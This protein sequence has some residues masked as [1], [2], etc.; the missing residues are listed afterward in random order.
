MAVGVTESVVIISD[1]HEKENKTVCEHWCEHSPGS[2]K[3]WRDKGRS[4]G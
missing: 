1:R 3:C 2:E 4:Q